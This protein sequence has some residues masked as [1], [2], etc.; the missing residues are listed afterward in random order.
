MNKLTAIT[1]DSVLAALRL[2]HG[3]ETEV[4]P[5][6][7]SRLGLLARQEQEAHSSLAEA[8]LAA[9]N[10]AIL[11]RG[12][13]LLRGITPEAEELLRDR[14]EHRREVLTLSNSLNVSESSFYYR[15]RQAIAQL[16][17]ILQQLEEEASHSWR[18]RMWQRLDLPSY[19][20][21]VGISEPHEQ[22]MTALLDQDSRFIISIDGLGGLGKTALADRLTR[23]LINTSR[24]DEI[25]WITAKQ[26]HI[27]MRGRL[28][29]ESGRPALTFPMVLDHLARQLELDKRSSLSELQKQRLV[30]QTLRDHACLV[31]IDNLETVADYRSLLPE[32]KKWRRPSKFLLTSRIR[33]LDEL[34]V[35]SYSLKELSYESALQLMRMESKR[36]GFASLVNAPD[37]ELYDIYEVVG[38]NPLAIKLVIG[39]LRLHALPRVLSR[40]AAGKEQTT[41]AEL[42]DY[43]YSEI[44][45]S[46]G[47][48]SKTTLLALTEA[49]ESGFTF[50]HLLPLTSLS[51]T[52]LEECL[53]E[54][55]LLSL[56]DLRGGL[57]ERYYRLH[58]LTQRFLLRMFAEDVSSE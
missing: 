25:A 16:T 34:E 38:G 10:R 37:K 7:H 6:N 44:W 36:T 31:V 21:L 17:E 3:G 41:R 26:T 33:L 23:D 43:I 22:L 29:I 45:E 12:L 30:K 40:F 54:L 32:L 5:L 47:D 48:D 9:K 13:A 11:N 55:I 20:E 1:T 24:F 18:E 39:Q 14:F 35:F 42:F 49:G 15:Q 46:L 19:S 58:R 56:V 28:Q 53:E 8:G 27:S 51:E 57:T 4:W 50:D 2:W 52:R